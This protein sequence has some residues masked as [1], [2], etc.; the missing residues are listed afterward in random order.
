[1]AGVGGCIQPI[2][3]VY[4]SRVDVEITRWDCVNC[5]EQLKNAYERKEGSEEEYFEVLYYVKHGMIL[6]LRQE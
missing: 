2:T 3:V 5:L 4:L 1:M 6:T